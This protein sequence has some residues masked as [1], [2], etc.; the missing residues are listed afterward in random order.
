MNKQDLIDV[1]KIVKEYKSQL[2]KKTTEVPRLRE[3]LAV[4]DSVNT[5]ES[6]CIEQ[7]GIFHAK[8]LLEDNK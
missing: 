5:I 2:R 3:L 4:L 8:E 7:L 1:I 6:K